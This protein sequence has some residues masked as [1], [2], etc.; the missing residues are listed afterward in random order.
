MTAFFKNRRRGSVTIMAVMILLVLGGLLDSVDGVILAL[1][2]ARWEAFLGRQVVP[3]G[4]LE[5][6]SADARRRVLVVPFS[7][8]QH[9]AGVYYEEMED[10]KS[11][12]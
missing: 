3:G 1:E 2:A 7:V 10:R 6:V 11:V 5:V 8:A 4:T 12:V 9:G